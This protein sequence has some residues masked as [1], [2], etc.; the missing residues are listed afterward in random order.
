MGASASLGWAIWVVLFPARRRRRQAEAQLRLPRGGPEASPDLASPTRGRLNSRSRRSV[1]SDVWGVVCSLVRRDEFALERPRFTAG[2]RPWPT[3]QTFTSWEVT[4][5]CSRG[6]DTLVLG[7]ALVVPRPCRPRPTR[8]VVGCVPARTW[9]NMSSRTLLLVQELPAVR[10]LWWQPDRSTWQGAR[11]FSDWTP[12]S[13]AADE[14]ASGVDSRRFR[15]RPPDLVLGQVQVRG[16]AC[17]WTRDG[18]HL[19]GSLPNF[20]A[21]RLLLDWKS[22]REVPMRRRRTGASRT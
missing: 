13:A 22:H 16:Q 4:P 19:V 17:P 6:F 11:L 18:V 21:N 12:V 10:E 8:V 15:A 14:K 2:N 9:A 5:S 20:M 3:A 7:L 1:L